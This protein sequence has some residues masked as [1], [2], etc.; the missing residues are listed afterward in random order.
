VIK[1]PIEKL[2]G[3]MSDNESAG[4]ISWDLAFAQCMLLMEF[5]KQQFMNAHKS[6]Q[7]SIDLFDEAS[8]KESEDYYDKIYGKR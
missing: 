4:K 7:D 6:G 1:T 8:F 2:V 5:E 3:W